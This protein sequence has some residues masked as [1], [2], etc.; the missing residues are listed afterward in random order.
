VQPGGDR[1]QLLGTYLL[2]VLD[3]LGECGIDQRAQ[4]AVFGRTASM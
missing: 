2:D 1:G 3:L 4:P